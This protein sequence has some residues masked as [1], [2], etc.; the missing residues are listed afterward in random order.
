MS[1]TKHPTVTNRYTIESFRVHPKKY[2]T[3]SYI[4]V[5]ETRGSRLQATPT[6]RVFFYLYIGW[7]QPGRKGTRATPFVHRTWVGC[8]TPCHACHCTCH[9]GRV[10]VTDRVTC[11]R[12]RHLSQRH[13]FSRH[14]RHRNPT[15]AQRVAASAGLRVQR[16]SVIPLGHPD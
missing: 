6:F 1:V 9:G 12:R 4:C 7:Y 14:L 2:F 8:R 13:D 10:R 11:A 15:K 16:P 3:D 5:P